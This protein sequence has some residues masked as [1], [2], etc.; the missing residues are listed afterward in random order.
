M[1]LVLPAKA[2]KAIYISLALVG[3][4]AGA[5]PVGYQAVGANVPH[6]YLAGAAVFSF[7]V[8]APFTLAVLNTNSGDPYLTGLPV[9]DVSPADD[10]VDDS[11]QAA[12]EADPADETDPG[13]PAP[14][15][16]PA[17]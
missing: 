11:N 12:D 10:P 14:D 16:A 3:L 6:W 7:V 8:A 5:I 2:R 1:D 9:A 17:A 15:P 13:Q 4:A